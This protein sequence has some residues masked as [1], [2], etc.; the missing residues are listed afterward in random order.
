MRTYRD[1]NCGTSGVLSVYNFHFMVHPHVRARV[2]I[3][4]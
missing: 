2:L 3:Y 4:D 1:G